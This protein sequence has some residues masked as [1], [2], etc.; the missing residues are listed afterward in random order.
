MRITIA[1]GE[2]NNVCIMVSEIYYAS[3]EAFNLEN[4]CFIAVPE[5][6]PPAG[7]LATIVFVLYGLHAFSPSKA[8]HHVYWLGIT[9]V[10]QFW[11]Q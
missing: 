9:T 1:A 4:V 10:P 5:F 7:H 8:I 6:E 3:V 11:Y 2:L